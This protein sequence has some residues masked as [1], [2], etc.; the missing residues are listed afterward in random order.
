MLLRSKLFAAA[1]GLLAALPA[2]AGVVKVGSGSYSDAFPGVD[3]AGRNGYPTATPQVSGKAATRPIPTNDWWSNELISDHGQSMFN[4]PLGL[5]PEND[6]L[7]IIKN[8]FNQATMLGDGPLKVSVDG[9]SC[10]QTTVSDHSDWTVTFSWNGQLEATVAQASP[11]VYFTR[12]AGAGNVSV[13][14]L[15]S[16]STLSGADNVLVITGSYNGANYAVYAPAGSS[17]NVSGSSASNSLGGKNYFSA[18]MLPSGADAKTTAQE[19]LK[20]AFVFPADTRAE[21]TYNQAAGTV[22]TTY[23]VTPDVKEGS[24]TNFLMG[25]L[26]HH[27][28]HVIGAPAY[29]KGTYATIRGEMKMLGANQFTTNLKFSGILP[30]LPAVTSSATGY[31]SADLN[32]LIDQVNQD[33][34]LVDW[35]DS[36]NDGQLLNRLVQIGR[37][38]A[39]S[40]YTA[41]FNKALQ[42][43][44]DRVE[45][46]LTYQQG[47]IAFMFYY[48][49][50]WTTL[51]GYPAGHGQDTNINDHHFHW[52]YIIGAAAF[53]EQYEPGWKDKWGPMIELLVRDG[54][55]PDRDDPMFPYLRNFA[56]Y[57][58]HSWANGTGNLGI[59]TDQESSSES[60]QFACSLIHWGGVTGNT[61]VRDLG[62]YL[63]ATELSAIEEYWFDIHHRVFTPDYT[64]VIASRIFTNGYDDKNF[65]GGGLAGSYGIEIY[66]VHAG[67]T[68]LARDNAFAK[69]YWD[70]MKRDTGILQNEDNGNIW[71]D[72]WIRYVAMINPTEALN[73]YGKCT[74]LGKKFG[75]SQ[76][77]T[78]QWVHAMA[79]MGTPATDVTA[80]FPFT[81][82]FENNGRRTY[83]AQNYGTSPV[84]VNFSDGYRLSVPAGKLV[85]ATNGEPLP[86]APTAT[87]SADPA[88]GKAGETTVFTAIVNP[89]DYTVSSASIT[90]NGEAIATT[91]GSANTYE[92]EWTPVGKGT[93]T[94]GVTVKCSDGREFSAAKTQYTVAAAG[95]T[96]GGGGST[97]GGSSTGGNGSYEYTFTAD[98]AS[99]GS[100]SGGGKVSLSYDGTDV[101]VR[102][103]FDGDYIGFVGP[104]LWNYTN[105]FAESDMTP[106]GDGYKATLS[107]YASGSVVKVAVK[108]AFA[109]GMGVTPIYEIKLDQPSAVTSPVAAELLSVWPNPTAQTLH[110]KG[111]GQLELLSL[112]GLKVVAA[113]VEGI[114]S[115][116][117][118]SL[119]AGYYIAVLR[120]DEGNVLAT[121]RVIKL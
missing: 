67:S 120:G 37:I 59:G 89:G 84:T 70:A 32:R 102:A 111:D 10:S 91:S 39:E 19:W 82:V 98:E 104:W 9:V 33:N 6:G 95:S 18:V 16:F 64:T 114:T 113:A 7:G 8:M 26:P 15:G 13:K 81:T 53:I 55:S 80:D 103:S 31:S 17:W 108:I 28:A 21:Y 112:T 107:G 116:D 63:Y 43:V 110:V 14:A 106:D 50:P 42:L 30:T 12:G 65:W 62:I 23:K 121:R 75:D 97:G 66:P 41:G 58:G 27:W 85:S 52:G 76:A 40:G 94:V 22:T 99:Q 105:G 35:T 1:L 74:Q 71:Y 69:S 86:A 115:L 100:F 87:L 4:Y 73:L 24:G 46:W 83:V 118:S 61:K 68:Y 11:F 54:G 88:E 5:R 51:V 90:V 38:A 57:A 25:L 109:G 77:H 101:T 29:E 20:Y 92:A 34:G 96:G 49:K 36:Y 72:A 56:P 47:D 2:Q 93:Y 79:A 3:Q 44:K 119:P 45:R 117:L 78:Y 60:M 48:H